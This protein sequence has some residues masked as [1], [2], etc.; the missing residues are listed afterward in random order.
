MNKTKYTVLTV[1]LIQNNVIAEVE[2]C[3]DNRHFY[4]MAVDDEVPNQEN[5]SNC[6][7]SV[8]EALEQAEKER[9]RKLS[10]HRE[11]IE[12]LRKMKFECKKIETQRLE[13]L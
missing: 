11:Q 6:Y 9:H 7:N 3:T 1:W 5:L 4:W 8:E 12:H 13:G 2:G 10:F